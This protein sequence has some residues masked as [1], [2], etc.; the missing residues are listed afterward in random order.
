[1]WEVDP[2]K[3][4]ALPGLPR[5]KD[6]ASLNL[7]RSI[8]PQTTLRVFLFLAMAAEATLVK[9][10]QD[11]FFEI[12][13]IGAARDSAREADQE[14][15]CFCRT[16]RQGVATLKSPLDSVE[17]TGRVNRVWN[18]SFTYRLSTANSVEGGTHNSAGISGTF[19]TGK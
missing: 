1:M 8:Q 19:S 12:Y 14:Y 2:D 5:F 17:E 11:V 10:W 6:A 7:C 13:R 18:S 16:H 9:Q 4:L 15:S 3:K